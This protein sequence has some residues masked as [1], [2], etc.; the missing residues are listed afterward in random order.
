MWFLLN[1]SFERQRAW[2]C[3]HAFIVIRS[4]FSRKATNSSAEGNH[5]CEWERDRIHLLD[6]LSYSFFLSGTTKMSCN[7]LCFPCQP[8]TSSTIL[9][10]ENT[11]S[12]DLQSVI[13]EKTRF[14]RYFAMCSLMFVF[15]KND[16]QN[17]VS[18]L[19]ALIAYGR[20]IL[21]GFVNNYEK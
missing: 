13:V 16:V 21:L 10:W 8:V 19:V 14:S 2:E 17:N 7:F 15:V 9:L 5:A 3:W 20:W 12:C 1:I 4:S 6:C 11:N 18:F